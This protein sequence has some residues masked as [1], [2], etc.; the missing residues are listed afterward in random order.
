M[1]TRL[2]KFLS[3]FLVAVMLLTAAPLSGF[4]GLD[5]NLDWLNF[6]TK[7]SAA[8][9]NG[10]CG[11]YLTWSLN[12]ETGELLITGTGAMGNYDGWGIDA[13]WYSYR[14]SI[15]SVTISAGVTTIGYEAFYDCTGLTSVTMGNSITIIGERAFI[16]CRSLTSVTIPDSVTTIG[17]YAFFDCAGLTNVTLGNGVTTIGSCA[18]VRCSS[19]LAFNVHKDSWAEEYAKNN[20]HIYYYIYG[21]NEV[22]SISV[23]VTSKLNFEIDKETYTLNVNCIGDML[24]FAENE[25]PPWIQYN[26]YIK[27]IVISD[28][29]TSIGNYA[30]ENMRGIKSVIIPDGV[31][32]IGYYSFY[33]CI[34]LTSV[35]IGKNVTTIGKYAFYNCDSLTNVIIPDSVT[36]IGAAAFYNCFSLTSLTIPNSVT[37]IGGSAFR[38]CNGLTSITIGSNV[39]SI[40]SNA[41]RD[42][43]SITNVTIPDSV[44]NM[45]ESVF[46]G[47]VS[48]ES[49][50]LSDTITSISKSLFY[51]CENLVD[52]IIPDNVK[53]IGNSAF[54]GCSSLVSINIPDGLK[55]IDGSAFYGCSNLESVNLPDG[56]E[57]IG[58]EAFYNCITLKNVTIP[59]SVTTI[60]PYTFY[61]CASFTD[62]TVPESVVAI[63]YAAFNSCSNL[64]SIKLPSSISAIGDYVFQNCSGLESIE[65]P[66]CVTTIGNYAFYGC[67]SLTSVYLPIN[68]QSVGSNAFVSCTNLKKLKVYNKSCIFEG[69]CIKNNTTLVGYA[70]STAQTYAKEMDLAFELI[71]DGDHEHVYSNSCDS[72]CNICGYVNLNAGHTYKTVVHNPTCQNEGFTVCICTVCKYAYVSEITDTVDHDMCWVV[73]T[74]PTSSADGVKHYSCSYCGLVE[75][76]KV[77]PAFLISDNS[78]ASIDFASNT[79]SGFDAGTTSVEDYVS[80]ETDGYSFTCDSAVIGTGTVI[81]LTDGEVVI[82]EFTAVIF[83]DVNG[84]GWYDGTDS[85]IVSCLANGLLSK[86]D[87]SPAFYQAADCNHDGVIDSFDVA[88][89]EQAGALLA[90]VDQS[91]SSDELATDA[92]YIEYLDLIDQTPET[93]PEVEEAP[94]PEDEVETPETE[95]FSIFKFIIELIKKFIEFIL[96]YIPVPLK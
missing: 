15:K 96:S 7:A 36:T 37:S 48:L 39:K 43:T 87:V 31:T 68:V 63:G 85:I 93:E 55:S 66:E 89:L 90:S 41:F 6:T 42:C 84:D 4:V 80:V 35:T 59:D 74:K 23:T 44:T 56:L 91:K 53:S 57:S 29:C 22:K 77:V 12:T 32:T 69:V 13:P 75:D 10:I 16:Y 50:I 1:K 79:I 19:E 58:E 26:P 61:G 40:A 64:I 25:D 3:V 73:I 86:D 27:Y 46:K 18:F 88:L 34:N 95:E 8:T 11:E 5:F 2:H 83:G 45:G 30:F 28:G 81:K 24:S 9:Y 71:T 17:E 62:I 72:E 60:S 82:N 47:C 54:Y 76:T 94:Q 20:N 67:A 52:L 78:V 51:G 65:I 33:D 70:G 92:A 38:Y 21:E 49:V 14:S